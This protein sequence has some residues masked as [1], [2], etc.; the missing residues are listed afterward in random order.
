MN[1]GLLDDR[2]RVRELIYLFGIFRAA[3]MPVDVWLQLNEMSINEAVDYWMERVPWLDADVARVDAEIYLRRPPGYG[4]GYM[5]GMVQM[6]ALLADRRRQLGNEFNL[7]EFHD[8]LMQS[9]RLPL[10]LLRWE[11][12]GLDDE[13]AT[14]WSRE[15]LP[16]HTAGIRPH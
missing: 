11:M 7:R 5:T 6:Q 8:A 15:A 1:A 13:V 14:L 16:T 3:R 2:P 4:L 9:G 10:S 12:T